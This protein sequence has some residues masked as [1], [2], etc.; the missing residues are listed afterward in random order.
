MLG[1]LDVSCFEQFLVY[2]LGRFRIICG[3]AKGLQFAVLDETEKPIHFIA[4]ICALQVLECFYKLAET[5]R[6]G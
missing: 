1:P 3:E 2:F 5:C 6:L 4:H